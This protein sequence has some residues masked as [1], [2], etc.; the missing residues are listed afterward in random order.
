[1]RSPR[2]CEDAVEV[3]PGAKAG[4]VGRLEAAPVGLAAVAARRHHD[5]HDRANQALAALD[6]DGLAVFFQ[7][8]ARRAYVSRPWLDTQPELRGRIEQLGS[9]VRS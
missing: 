3:K 9:S 5:A 2:P 1:M 6:A 7:A 4:D 8:V